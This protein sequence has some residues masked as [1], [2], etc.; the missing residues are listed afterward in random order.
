MISGG[1][2]N[3]K[4]ADIKIKNVIKSLDRSDPLIIHL[5]DYEFIP[6]EYRMQIVA[7]FNYYIKIKIGVNTDN[8]YIHLKIFHNLNNKYIILNIVSDKK[9]NDDITFF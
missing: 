6:I 5:Q 8:K 9:I 3:T 1:L 2:S 4:K 7:G